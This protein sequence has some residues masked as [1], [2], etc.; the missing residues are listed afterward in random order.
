M[1]CLAAFPRVGG[2]SCW[3]RS[4]KKISYRIALDSPNY[5][6]RADFANSANLIFAAD[7]AASHV[8]IG[9]VSCMPGEGR[10]TIAS[11][12]AFLLATS[13]IQSSWSMPTS[14]TPLL[15]LENFAPD[16]ALSLTETWG[17]LM[18]H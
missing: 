17:T 4:P 18:G 12:L 8:S 9:V 11:N 7:D 14:A 10:T 1:Y 3:R 6:L 16:A 2:G 5:R 13:V 15:E